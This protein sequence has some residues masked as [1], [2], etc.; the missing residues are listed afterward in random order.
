ML[1]LPSKELV[2]IPLDELFVGDA[3]WFIV[4]DVE[5]VS[6]EY[7]Q[8]KVPTKEETKT[9]VEEKYQ[10]LDGAPDRGGRFLKVNDPVLIYTPS[11]F[12]DVNKSRLSDADKKRFLSQDTAT[13]TIKEIYAT[14]KRTV[15]FLFKVDYS[16]IMEAFVPQSS[17]ESTT[18]PTPSEETGFAGLQEN[19]I[20]YFI[21]NYI[22]N[23]EKSKGD[24]LT[25][26]DLLNI[27][28]AL[29]DYIGATPN[30]SVKQIAIKVLDNAINSYQG[31]EISGATYI[32]LSPE[33][34]KEELSEADKMRNNLM[35]LS[36]E[37]ILEVW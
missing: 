16:G 33:E 36:K 11:E 8:E 13:G 3:E 4:G 18:A 7:L 25:E 1:L 24:R 23:M 30:A 20:G 14:G 32:N 17:L 26:K 15:P 34:K 9:V 21:D 5:T 37:L 2:T 31:K 28:N 19:D 22:I 27:E 12:F 10:S 6:K 35:A 29:S